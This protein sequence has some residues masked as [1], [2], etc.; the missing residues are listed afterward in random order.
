VRRSIRQL[1]SAVVFVLSVGTSAQSVAAQVVDAQ[2][3]SDIKEQV[4][5]LVGPGDFVQ[6][7]GLD[8]GVNLLANAKTLRNAVCGTPGDESNG[9]PNQVPIAPPPVVVVTPAV[10]ATPVP[11]ADDPGSFPN[12]AACL[13]ASEAEVTAAMKQAV[14]ASADD[15][16]GDPSPIVQ[17]CDYNGAGA[18]FATILYFQ[19]NASFLY[20]SLRSTADANGVQAVPGLGDRAFVYVGGEGPGVVVAKGDRVVA[21]EFHGIGNGP[22]ERNSLLALVQ[23]AVNRIP[24]T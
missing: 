1:C 22:V 17:G 14:T 2:A 7:A 21:L 4:A 12:P 15:P 9:P 20:D 5:Y 24:A 8:E 3:C 11:V 6:Q 19:A 10:K 18:A 13:L 23:Q 16:L